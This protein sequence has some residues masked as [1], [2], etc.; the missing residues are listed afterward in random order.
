MP[1]SASNTSFPLPTNVSVFHRPL[2]T[3]KETPVKSSVNSLQALLSLSSDSEEPAESKEN[4][5][6]SKEN[7]EEPKESSKESIENSKES[8]ENSKEPKENSKES[9]ENSKEPKDDSKEPS[10]D[11]L[12]LPIEPPNPIAT[13]TNHES[14]FVDHPSNSIEHESNEHITH[15]HSIEPLSP[16][17]SIESDLEPIIELSKDAPS[18]PI[19][20]PFCV[21]C[22]K[23]GQYVCDSTDQ[24]VCSLECKRK[25]E[26]A[27]LSSLPT[28]SPTLSPSHLTLSHEKHK[29]VEVLRVVPT[30]PQF[31]PAKNRWKDGISPL[32]SRKCPIC[33]KTGHLAQDC[34]F[35]SGKLVE[36]VGFS[37]NQEEEEEGG[38]HRIECESLPEW[39]RREVSQTK[40]VKR[41]C[42]SYSGS[43]EKPSKTPQRAARFAENGRIWCT[44][45]PAMPATATSI[46]CSII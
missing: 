35:A 40:G 10:D 42:R 39:Q 1:N 11:S 27:A 22:G 37:R 31:I 8:M 21:I 26:A 33:G 18:A 20:G 43:A 17:D 38:K 24:D 34:H 3:P 30:A 25:A 5:K 36:F 45:W 2:E 6:E 19:V 44:A 46:T 7:L 14:S 12:H 23:Y 28:D 32:D 41:S 29:E 9:M 13:P 16:S 4:S 15:P